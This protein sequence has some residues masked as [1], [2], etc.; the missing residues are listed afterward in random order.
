MKIIYKKM[1][2]LNNLTREDKELLNLNSNAFWATYF[3]NRGTKHAYV[4]T[5][6]DFTL[7]G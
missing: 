5:L 6:S 3:R 2:V 4:D 7:R 1:D